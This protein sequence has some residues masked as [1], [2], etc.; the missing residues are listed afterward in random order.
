MRN[1][2][3]QCAILAMLLALPAAGA[4]PA[5][6]PAPRVPGEIIVSF[7]AGLPGPA[8]AALLGGRHQ[9]TFR[10]GGAELWTL[11]AGVD[12]EDAVATLAADPR[13]AWVEPNYLIVTQV[14]PDDPLVGEQWS[15]HNTGQTIGGQTGIPDADIDAPE[16]W[17]LTTGSPEVV[18]AVL[19]TGI[20]YRHPDLAANMWHNP[21]ETPG[22]G[23]DD[24]RNGFVDDALGWDFAFEDSDPLDDSSHGTHCA[25]I[26]GAVADN[27]LGVTG[28][29]PRTRIMAVKFQRADGVGNHADAVRAIDYAVAMGADILSCSWGST[30]RSEAMFLALDAA[31]Q[32][33]VFVV[34]AAGNLGVDNDAQTYYP[35]GYDL[36]NVISVMASDN[37]DERAVME[38]W[39]SNFG[40]TSVDLAAPGLRIW[41]TVRDGNHMYLSGTSMATPHVAGALALML[42]RFPDT[43]IE[44]G[45]RLLLD[46]GVDPLP[47]LAGL[48]ATGARLNAY[49]LV[50]DPDTIAPG[51]VTDLAVTETASNRVELGWTEPAD[52]QGVT[53]FVVRHAPQPI[54][55]EAAWATATPITGVP[56]PAGVGASLR[57]AVRGL[58]ADQ[59]H[60]F[61]VRARDRYG[62]ESGLSNAAWT[63]TLPAPV[64]EVA[65]GALE[66]PLPLGGTA[67]RPLRITNAGPGVLDF[68]IPQGTAGAT[69]VQ[70]PGATPA[71]TPGRGGPDAFGYGWADDEAAGGPTWDWIDI[72][73]HGT[74]VQRTGHSNQGP[75]PIGF[76]FPFYG[77]LFEGFTISTHGCVSLTAGVTYGANVALPSPAAPGNL[78]ALLWD[79][80]DSDAGTCHYLADG[81]RVIVQYTG[82]TTV[83]GHGPFTMQLRFFPDGIIEYLYLDMAASAT[84]ATVGIQNGDGSVG[85]T[86]ASG[87]DGWLRAG[88]AVRLAPPPRWIATLPAAG[89]LGAGESLDVE[90]V[91]EAGD[92][93]ASRLLADLHLLSNDPGRPAVLVPVTAVLTGEAQLVVAPDH[94]DFGGINVSGTAVRQLTLANAACV[95]VVVSGITSSD[96]QFGADVDL[97]LVLA[98]GQAAQVPVSCAPGA[99]GPVSATLTLES[100]DAERPLIQVALAG[101]GLPAPD[102]VVTPQQFT[103]ALAPG[104]RLERVLTITNRGVGPLVLASA[105]IALGGSAPAAWVAADAITDTLAP[106]TERAWTLVFDASVVC[107]GVWLGQA[108]VVTDDPDQPLLVVP[109]AMEVPAA[110]DPRWESAS[111]D[112][113][114]VYLGQTRTIDVVLHN[115]GCA[116][117]AI[118]GVDTD[119]PAFAVEPATPFTLASGAARTFGVLFTPVRG[120]DVAGALR[121]AT[122]DPDFPLLSLPLRAVAGLEPPAIGL[123]AT[124]LAGTVDADSMD[125]RLVQVRNTGTGPLDFTVEEVQS[126]PAGSRAEGFVSPEGHGLRWVDSRNSRGPAF[127]W[128]D[129]VGTGTAVLTAGN[130]AVNGPLP[131]PF[132]FNF[133]GTPTPWFWVSANGFVSFNAPPPASSEHLELPHPDAPYLMVAPYWADLDLDAADSGDVWSA[134]VDGRLVVQWDNVRRRSPPWRIT[135]ETIIS[136]DGTIRFQYLSMPGADQAGAS[137]GVQDL[138]GTQG[139]CVMNGAGYAADSLAI[140]ISP[141]PRWATVTPTS[142]RI[143]PGEVL[144][145]RVAFAAAGLPEGLHTGSFRILSNDPSQPAVTV[146][147]SFAVATEDTTGGGPGQPP[148]TPVTALAGGAPNPFREGTQVRFSLAEAGPVQLQVFDLR[149]AL[150]QTLAEGVHMAGAHEYR[151][152]GRDRRGAPAATGIYVCRLRSPAGVVTRR[153][154]LLR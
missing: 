1:R 85:L 11:P 82:V 154:T 77:R 73:G 90:V 127:A 88:R 121:V 10:A 126:R 89:S 37:R 99:L 49:R 110:P 115:R 29:S 39:E 94:L 59:T 53:A 153:L 131:M 150:V 65:T 9:H 14:L 130:N 140:E 139:L 46:V 25:G 117:L 108:N 105:S 48:C 124:S 55:D 43:G 114:P 28:V 12:V 120:Q 129:I 144:D 58:P 107:G 44:R 100:N 72:A 7:R 91:L 36:P 128:V 98:A 149:G 76:A 83:Q 51:P 27:G 18:V 2:R 31:R 16:A 52:D 93:C 136:P 142:G 71:P 74:L 137:I 133:Y 23:V 15:L 79:E 45:R 109:L 41:S 50:A 143:P 70:A 22:N 34:A 84:D 148:A 78:L 146:G 141:Q 112:F 13:V 5:A 33:G 102:I 21:G 30:S 116:P 119:H 122:D 20:D 87:A 38:N 69:P 101:T 147:L 42:A 35:A 67:S 95:E 3:T 123:S 60:H 106:G 6:E 54:L 63:V 125:T 4:P 134:V 111:V 145:L 118:T 86:V 151:W 113:G 92:V 62:N 80:L 57:L 97:P 8:K 152:N 132:D 47:T 138:G 19:D 17:E 61:A 75:F 40:A 32:A 26:I 68:A 64:L 56:E 135:F 66:I 104:A 96:P 24:D 103:V 81:D